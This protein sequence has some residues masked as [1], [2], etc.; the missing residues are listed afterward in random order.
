MER[1]R[2]VS[3]AWVVSGRCLEG[4]WRVSGRRLGDVWRVDGGYMEA[5]LNKNPHLFFTGRK[6]PMC[7][8]GV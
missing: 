5:V 4:I 6:G 7:L 3:G 8:G 1:I 2:I